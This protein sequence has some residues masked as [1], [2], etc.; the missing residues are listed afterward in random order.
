[1]IVQRY[2]GKLSWAVYQGKVLYRGHMCSPVGR[3]NLLSTRYLYSQ[4]GIEVE[5]VVELPY[6]TTPYSA[7]AGRHHTFEL[8]FSDVCKTTG[9]CDLPVTQP[10]D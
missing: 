1:M 2:L 4:T 9:A 3:F 6:R 5:K 10:A 7:D 8:R